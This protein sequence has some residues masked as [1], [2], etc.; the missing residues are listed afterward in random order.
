MN[1]TR[2]EM[3]DKPMDLREAPQ[4]VAALAAHLQRMGVDFFPCARPESVEQWKTVFADLPAPL[5]QTSAGETPAAAMQG[6]LSPSNPLPASQDLRATRGS[7]TPNAGVQKAAETKLNSAPENKQNFSATYPGLAT[8]ATQRLAVFEEMSR[9]VAACMRCEILSACRTKTV[10]G[11]GN[12]STRFVFFGEGPGA[13]E[14]RSGRPFVGRSGELLTKMIEACTLRREDVY[15]MNTVKCR[16]PGN[17]NPESDEIENCRPYFERQFEVIRPEFIIC[18]GAVSM[19]SLLNSTAPI[20]QMRGKVHAYQGSRVIVTYHPAY[21]LRTPAA[22]KAAWD[23]LKFFMA[24]AGITR[25]T[26]D[27]TD[28]VSE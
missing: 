3:T 18:L 20:G 10:F 27:S 8:A 11:E 21:L 14:D 1:F 7:A 24:Q 26:K 16:P 17:R 19:K 5:E 6:L 15:I 9:D 28:S 2:D 12:P 25:H 23:D 4:A 22:K 13:D